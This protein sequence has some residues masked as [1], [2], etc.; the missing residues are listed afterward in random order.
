MT[1]IVA[2]F[3]SA[4]PWKVVAS[5]YYR[6]PMDVITSGTFK[7]DDKGALGPINHETSCV[8]SPSKTSCSTFNF[9]FTVKTYMSSY[10]A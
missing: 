1:T 5:S 10:S 6:Q 4:R 9:P 7:E 8:S 3:L 2:T